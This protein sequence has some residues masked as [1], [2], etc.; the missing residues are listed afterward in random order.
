MSFPVSCHP[1]SPIILITHWWR[2]GRWGGGGEKGFPHPLEFLF[3]FFILAT[4][5]KSRHNKAQPPPNIPQNCVRSLGNSETKNRPLEIPHA[6]SLTPGNSISS[7][8]PLPFWI[9][10]ISPPLAAWK[11]HFLK[12]TLHALFGFFLE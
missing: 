9:F 3:F 5:G 7:T 10:L 11:F 12:L 1:Y 4:P 6:I 2:E 8:T